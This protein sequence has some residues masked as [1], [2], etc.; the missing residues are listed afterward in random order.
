MKRLF[1]FGCS[2][3]QYRWPTWADILGKE[4]DYFE[5]WGKPGGG[6][7]FIFNSLNECLIKNSITK[8]DL[9]A[10]MWTNVAREDRYVNNKWI[11]PGNIYTQGT[12]NKEFVENFADPKGY[13]IRDL[14]FVHSAKKMLESYDIPHVFMSMVPIDNLDQ[15][16]V[17]PIDNI[18]SILEQYQSTISSIRPS[19]FETVFNSDWK[20]KPKRPGNRDLHPLPANY[21]EYIVKVLNE[22]TVSDKTKSWVNAV[23]DR[24]M[25][26][27][28]YSDLWT[29]T[30]HFPN[31]W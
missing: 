8:N 25:Q 21:L 15:Y 9:V 29:G 5:N 12:Y 17:S 3:T 11:V 2:F 23:N 31:R 20:S 16:F 26:K 1:A 30:I 10:V 18:S 27:Q 13:L 24:L 19:I 4:F 28:N 7:Q 6:N 22:Y 14:A